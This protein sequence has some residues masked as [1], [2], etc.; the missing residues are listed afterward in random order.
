VVDV[1]SEREAHLLGQI[2]T[3]GS[4]AEAQG[5]REQLRDQGEFSGAIMVRLAERMDRLAKNE[6]RR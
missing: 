2:K 4:L 6:A 5:F 1:T 3:L